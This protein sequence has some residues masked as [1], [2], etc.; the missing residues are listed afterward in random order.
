MGN[1]MR[2]TF[3]KRYEAYVISRSDTPQSFTIEKNRT[4]GASYNPY[5]P[6]PHPLN[7]YGNLQHTRIDIFRLAKGIIDVVDGGH[8][9]NKDSGDQKP[10]RNV[11]HLKAGERSMSMHY[12]IL[13]KRNV[14]PQNPGVFCVDFF[15][16]MC[17]R[18]H[19]LCVCVVHKRL[20]VLRV[21]V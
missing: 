2:D 21:F 19:R 13:S 9:Q 3:H 18:H 16:Q 12:F 15:L 11:H 7:H 8:N 20:T 1:S 14:V 6:I 5:I 10:D 4:K 17:H